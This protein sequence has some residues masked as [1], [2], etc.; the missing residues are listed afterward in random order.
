[1]AFILK[2]RILPKKY[3]NMANMAQMTF[4]RLYSLPFRTELPVL[5]ESHSQAMPR[6]INLENRLAQKPGLHERISGF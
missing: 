2:Y 6:F 3:Q 5:G 1:M 4:E